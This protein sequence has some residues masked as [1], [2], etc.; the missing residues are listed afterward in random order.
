[1]KNNNNS[2]NN[3]FGKK[4]NFLCLLAYYYLG[5][6]RFT[7]FFIHKTQLVYSQYST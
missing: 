7:Y 1:M 4:K 5:F 6:T 2:S 3:K